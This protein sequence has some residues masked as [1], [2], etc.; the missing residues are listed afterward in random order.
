MAIRFI[1]DSASD[2]LPGELPGTVYMPMKVIFGDREYLDRVEL[3]DRDF[4][5]ELARSN[6]FPTTCQIPPAEFDAAYAAV[7][8]AGDTAV[9]ITMSSKLSGTW[10]SAMIAAQDYPGKVF[11]VDSRNATLGERILIQRGCDL[12]SQGYCAEQIALT[13]TEERERIC[14]L[15]LLDT[16]E[17]LKKGGRISAA[18][19]LAGSLLSIKPVVAVQD[20]EVVMV[21]KARGSRQGNNR[22]R[23]L[24]KNC[25]GIDFQMPYSLAYSGTED[26][27]LQKYIADSEE[28]WRGHTQTLPIATVGSVIGTHVGPGAIAVAFFR[29]SGRK[30]E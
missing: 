14:L 13:L 26:T 7:T 30:T 21:G 5:Q 22:L 17:Y 10:Q 15:A 3:S 16:L 28:L 1:I 12:R 4:Y 27:L 19:A 29:N 11:V 18:T 20:G 2:I 8:G 6:T 24:V 25:G 9:V 23:E